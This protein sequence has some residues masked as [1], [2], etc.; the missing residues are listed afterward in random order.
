MA[1]YL[2]QDGV[3]ATAMVL[4]QLYLQVYILV[5]SVGVTWVPHLVYEMLFGL[6]VVYG[7]GQVRV[8]PIA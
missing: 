3:R 4:V 8:Y 1:D 6:C 5:Q 2:H 7:F